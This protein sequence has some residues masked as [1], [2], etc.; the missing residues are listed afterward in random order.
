MALSDGV[1]DH[2]GGSGSVYLRTADSGF[3]EIEAAGRTEE[4][5]FDPASI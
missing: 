4:E 3:T 5:R 2:T 1:S